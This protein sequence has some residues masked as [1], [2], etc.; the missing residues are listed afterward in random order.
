MSCRESHAQISPSH[1]PLLLWGTENLASTG[2]AKTLNLLEQYQQSDVQ[3]QGQEPSKPLSIHSALA[4]PTIRRGKLL[5]PPPLKL[6]CPEAAAQPNLSLEFQS[7]SGADGGRAGSAL[8]A[9]A[10]APKPGTTAADNRPAR[11]VHPRLRR[12][13]PV[14]E[15]RMSIPG[16]LCPPSHTCC[17][18]SEVMRL[19][20]RTA[21]KRGQTGPPWDPKSAGLRPLCAS[22]PPA[23][24]A[25]EPGGP[26][27][28]P[29]WFWV[30]R[31]CLPPLPPLIPFLSLTDVPKARLGTHQIWSKAL[32]HY[33]GS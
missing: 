21:H 22:A 31:S 6:P 8:P 10:S 7:Q 16:V 29:E 13:M 30:L 4:R 19:F 5:L 12:S 17:L 24:D 15:V 33:S 25:D 23:E 26:R 11:S 14:Q 20:L 2:A 3:S 9:C 32:I 28:L 18:P 1:G 27:T